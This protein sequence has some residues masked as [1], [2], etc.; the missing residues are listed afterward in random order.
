MFLDTRKGAFI[1]R[2]DHLVRKKIIENGQ[3]NQSN[4]QKIPIFVLPKSIQIFRPPE[5]GHT[6]KF[7][8][9]TQNHAKLL[10][11]H[12]KLLQKNMILDTSMWLFTSEADQLPY[13]KITENHPK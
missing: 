3:K 1:S 7:L 6:K 2:P 12:P 13:A 9:I 10:Q 5:I 11:N 8:K 4:E